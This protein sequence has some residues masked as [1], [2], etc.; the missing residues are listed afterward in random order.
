[1]S[2][3]MKKYD[4]FWKEL[5]EKNGEIDRDAVARELFDYSML[6]DNTSKVFDDITGGAISKPN[7]LASE[8]LIEAQRVSQMEA[9][10]YAAEETSDLRAKLAASEAENERLKCELENT[11]ARL[12]VVAHSVARAAYGNEIA[13]SVIETAVD[14]ANNSIDE[15]N[16]I[17]AS[18]KASEE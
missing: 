6:I 10:E 17:V 3:Y 9:E 2:D 13:G 12:D 1:M 16:A 4:D 15:L 14:M 7:T 18:E 11:I 5:V 8:V